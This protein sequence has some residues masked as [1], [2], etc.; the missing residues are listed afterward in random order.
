MKP[1][2]NERN[3]TKCLTKLQSPLLGNPGSAIENCR[4]SWQI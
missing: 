4:E 1:E 3:V 2:A